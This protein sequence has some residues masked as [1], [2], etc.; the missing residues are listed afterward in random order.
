[1]K[2]ALEEP[3]PNGRAALHREIVRKLRL[4]AEAD[5]A[6]DREV[7]VQEI[8]NDVTGRL[9]PEAARRLAFAGREA[10]AFWQVLAPYYFSDPTAADTVLFLCKKLWAQ[11]RIPVILTLLLHRWLLL[12]REAGGLEQ[13]TKHVTV[14]ARGAAW[15]LAGDANSGAAVYEP[16]FKFLAFEI[17]LGLDKEP[18]ESLPSEA[19]RAVLS[20]VAS[21]LP[22]YCRPAETRELLDSFPEPD[23]SAAAAHAEG[24]AT[25]FVLG[26]V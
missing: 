11:P 10:A 7:I 22:Y 21:F 2:D 6:A 16:L 12:R 18:L 19:R 4:A 3:G 9:D 14:L 17:T 24:G 8:F 5:L 15:L 1:M 20:V 23:K 13:R 26:Q 25:D